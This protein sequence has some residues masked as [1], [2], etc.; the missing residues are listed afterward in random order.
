MNDR[1]RGGDV[2]W[3]VAAES[4]A[5]PDMETRGA[6]KTGLLERIRL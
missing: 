4:T 5:V 2:L 3:S 1:L 6:T